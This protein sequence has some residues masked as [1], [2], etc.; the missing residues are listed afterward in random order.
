MPHKTGQ[1]RMIELI[2]QERLGSGHVHGLQSVAALD[3]VFDVCIVGSGAAGAVAAEAFVTAGL[4]VILIEEGARLAPSALYNDVN[5]ASPQA[6]ARDG[7]AWSERGWPWSTRN[8]GGGT[9]FYGGASFRYRPFDFNPSTRIHTEG[10]DVSWPIGADDLAP[11]YDAI[12]ARLSVRRETAPVV[13]GSA[14]ATLSLP[15]EHLWR[16]AAACG[17]AALPTPVAIDWDRCDRCSLCICEQCGS[18]AKA[19]AVRTFIAPLAGKINFHLR[20]GVKAI[21]LRQRRRGRADELVCLDE[22]GGMTYPVRARAFVIA[23]NAIQSAALLLRSTSVHAP[24]G[25][26]NGCDMVG[27]GLCMKLSEY[28]EG[29]TAVP[30]EDVKR[31]PVGYRGPFSTVSVLDHYLDDRCP[32]GVGGLIY[33][34]KHDNWYALAGRPLVLRVETIIADHPTP[35]NRVRLSARRDRWG[36]PG[37]VID[38]RPDSRDL[39]RLDY[40]L[41]RSAEWLRNSGVKS[42]TRETSEFALG[43]TH[44]HGTC[45]AGHDPATSVVDAAGRVHDVDNVFVA[46]GSYMPY[47]GGLNPTLT[48]QA[49]ALRIARGIIASGVAGHASSGSATSVQG[50]ASQALSRSPA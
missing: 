40:M 12:E 50:Q 45:R 21:A 18:G 6:A 10:L 11:F 34:A 28:S 41:A 30:A 47:P 42:V 3:R 26:G 5:R 4:D 37:I 2:H 29:E 31:H 32:T 7:T 39:A 14:P 16:G 13:G 25:L 49:N 35:A 22:A 43:S 15:G 23:G 24:E 33:E 36:V 38:Y 48:I 1:I 19:D 44:L 20:T 27:R 46:D 8:L 9:V 17:Y